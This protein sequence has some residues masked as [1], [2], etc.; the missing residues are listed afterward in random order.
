MKRDDRLVDLFRDQRDGLWKFFLAG[1]GSAEI[2][3][4]LLQETFVK[5][6]EHREPLARAPG[7]HDGIGMRRWLWR[8]ARNRMIDEI[9]ARQRGRA[10]SAEMVAEPPAAAEDPTADFHHGRTRKL[11]HQV[12]ADL[13]NERSRRCLELW[14]ADR[15]FA[16][17]ERETGL[18]RAQVRGL[19]QRAKKDVISET[20]HRMEQP[21]DGQGDHE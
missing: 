6:W 16:D 15:S 12:V 18:R 3:E 20:L 10:R 19:L 5:L 1:A 4:D 13:P 11:M 21:G 17:I 14:L 2:A 8:V 7:Y 9:R